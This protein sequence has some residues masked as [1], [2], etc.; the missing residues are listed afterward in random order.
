MSRL[1]DQLTWRKSKRS[2]GDG[3]GNECVEVAELP[4]GGV[5]LRNSILGE[6][7][8]VVQ[9]TRGEIRAFLLGVKDGE[10]DDLM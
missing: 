10:F 5:A 3:G 4:N 9:Y 1:T 7:S 8:P 6:A 2:T